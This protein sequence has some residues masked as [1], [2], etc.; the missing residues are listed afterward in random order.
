MF[1]HP[2]GR[3]F[4]VEHDGSVHEPVQDGGGDDGVPED[5]APLG[6]PQLVVTMVEFPSW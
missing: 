5:L 4:D 2:P 1:S 3:A 6:S